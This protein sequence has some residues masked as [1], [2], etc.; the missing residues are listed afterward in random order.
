MTNVV[1]VLPD[2]VDSIGRTENVLMHFKHVN[3]N[4]LKIVRFQKLK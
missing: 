4:F 2:I 1:E 3:E